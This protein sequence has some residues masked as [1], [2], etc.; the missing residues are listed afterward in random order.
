M[1]AFKR[2]EAFPF[3]LPNGGGGW[4]R[5]LSA[6]QPPPPTSL[7]VGQAAIRPRGCVI[8]RDRDLNR[9]RGLRGQNSNSSN[10]AIA[11]INRRVQKRVSKA[12]RSLKRQ[13]FC[14]LV[15]F[16]IL[17]PSLSDF[18][19]ISIR[20]VVWI[21]ALNAEGASGQTIATKIEYPVHVFSPFARGLRGS[22][23]PQ[24]QT[25]SN[26]HLHQWLVSA[27]RWTHM[28]YVA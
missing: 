28:T 10:V 26:S 3:R 19:H 23:N 22:L 5:N 18:A 13:V 1:S 4:K 27:R 6:K 9:L 24:N 11:L 8:D 17:A 20:E 25:S 21:G 14:L 2:S 15:V 7:I 16:E 12:G